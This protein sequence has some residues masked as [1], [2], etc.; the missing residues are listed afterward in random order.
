MAYETPVKG[1]EELLVSNMGLVV[2][3]AKK[4]KPHSAEQLDEFVQIGRGALLT[5]IRKLDPERGSLATL[6]WKCI[7]RKLTRHINSQ[8][9][10]E[11]QHI[12]ENMSVSEP[13]I[14]LWELLPDSLTQQERQVVE[15]RNEGYHFHEIGE[16]LGGYT[17]GWAH[18]L[19]H[20]A[21][22]KI[23]DANT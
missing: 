10:H 4:F 16:I 21:L 8:R 3:L 19:F 17:K 20:S 2:H 23:Q 1:E 6:A 7:V 11:H 9:K 14:P 13:T 15:L 5:A 18:K 12:H 22:K